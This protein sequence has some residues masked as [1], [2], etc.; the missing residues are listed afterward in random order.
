[1]EIL[2]PRLEVELEVGHLFE[3][4]CY[5]EAE[6]WLRLKRCEHVPS[7]SQFLSHREVLED[8]RSGN[9]TVHSED[10]T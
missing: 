4:A 6:M 7:P 9:S 1:M 2:R 8:I 3:G 10:H 5:G